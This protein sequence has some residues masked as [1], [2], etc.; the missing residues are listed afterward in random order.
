MNWKYDSIAQ[1]HQLSYEGG[2]LARI[3]NNPRRKGG[4]KVSTMIS[5]I[6]FSM[7]KQEKLEK[8]KKEWVA[9]HKI[10]K[11]KTEAST[12]ITRKKEIVKKFI[13]VRE[14]EA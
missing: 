9:Y 4:I 11:N 2:I 10:F 3:Q 5:A 8:Q 6:Y 7:K 14:K 13:Q 1:E 12:Y